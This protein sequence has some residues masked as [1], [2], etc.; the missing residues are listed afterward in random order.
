MPQD[1]CNGCDSYMTKSI[2]FE[3][4]TAT[5]CGRSVDHKYR[6]LCRTVWLFGNPGPYIT[7]G[8]AGR[9]ARGQAGVRFCSFGHAT[10]F[11]KYNS[12]PL[13]KGPDE[14]PAINDWFFLILF[15]R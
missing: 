2:V 8:R 6:L 10:L 3:L 12:D 11:K 9:A 15:K 7:Y 5:M 13:I 4:P 1:E 14:G